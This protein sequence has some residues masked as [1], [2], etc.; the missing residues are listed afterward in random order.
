[1]SHICR[2]ATAYRLAS[3]AYGIMVKAI[4]TSSNEEWKREA[5]DQWL[6]NCEDVLILSKEKI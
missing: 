4:E 6:S 5:V 1:M 3:M 2:I